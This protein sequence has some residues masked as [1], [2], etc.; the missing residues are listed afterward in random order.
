MSYIQQIID[1]F[2]HHSLSMPMIDR[3]HR[4][5]VERK[6]EKEQE[7]ACH[8]LWEEIGFPEN[9]RSAEAA[10]KRLEAR[11]GLNPEV[12]RRPSHFWRWMGVAAIWLV[13]LLLLSLS[14]HKYKKVEEVQQMLED[15]ALVEH[16]VSTG[17]QEMVLLPDSSRVWLNSESVLV[18]PSRFLGE[19]R[20]VYLSGEGYFEVKKDSACPF[21]V[22]VRTLNIEVLGTRFD[23][24]AYP[25]SDEI[26]TTLE[27]GEV[28]VRLKEVS[29]KPYPLQPNEQLIYHVNSKEVDVRQV[30]SSD[31]SDWRLGGL[32]FDNAS[33]GEVLR[34]IERSH[35]VHIR[36]QTSIHNDNRLTVHFKKHET[37]ENIF[38]LLKEL[39]PG[40][41]YQ[42]DGRDIYI[43]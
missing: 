21:I 36:L 9:E 13:P 24:R 23:V 20:K 41:E 7:E 4:R 10:Y 6:D 19:N 25:E 15:V 2:Y 39:I 37:L 12:G 17:K 34:T 18:Y 8:A 16:F 29:S 32:Y 43:E 35:A 26:K 3:V 1:Y 38:M 31:Y 5:M 42:I 28:Q 11:L 14:I 22:N 27:E 40:L 33:F 30:R